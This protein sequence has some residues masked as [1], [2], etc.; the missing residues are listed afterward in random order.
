MFFSRIRSFSRHWAR[1]SLRLSVQDVP[2]I[3]SHGLAFL[4]GSLLIKTHGPLSEQM[5]RQILFPLD[6]M[7]VDKKLSL[8]IHEHTALVLVKN[9]NGEVCLW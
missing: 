9:Q 8:A 4:A 6:G 3:M 1:L 2:P 7:K 5:P